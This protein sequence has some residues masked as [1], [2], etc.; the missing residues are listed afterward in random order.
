MDRR[1]QAVQVIQAADDVAA[2]STGLQTVVFV[3]EKRL[4]FL[5]DVHFEPKE[6]K[7]CNSGYKSWS[8]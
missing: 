2:S 1:F 4:K 6:K 3:K 8:T 7:P 5:C